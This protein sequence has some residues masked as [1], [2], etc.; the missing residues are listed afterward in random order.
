MQCDHSHFLVHVCIYTCDTKCDIAG[1][2]TKVI[3][4]FRDIH[5]QTTVIINQ[6][7]MFPN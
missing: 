7:I 1:H 6:G 5:F 2:Y 4:T 3:T